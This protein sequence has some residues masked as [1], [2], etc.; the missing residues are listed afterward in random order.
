LLEGSSEI[1]SLWIAT[2]SC[3][4]YIL[5][6]LFCN[7]LRISWWTVQHWRWIHQKTFEIDIF[8]CR[9]WSLMSL[10]LH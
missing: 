1:S 6:M 3:D 2:Y 7:H 8:V 9:S 4:K 10:Y 5:R